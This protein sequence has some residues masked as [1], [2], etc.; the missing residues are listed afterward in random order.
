MWPPL[1]SIPPNHFAAQAS[2]LS[3]TG[4]VCETSTS[5]PVHIPGFGRQIHVFVWVTVS[6]CV[7]FHIRVFLSLIVQPAQE[8]QQRMGVGRLF[9]LC[10]KQAGEVKGGH[11]PCPCLEESKV[12]TW[13]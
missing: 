2:S 3:H 9:A 6:P 12:K 5:V 7:H 11:D 4:E 8:L 10:L 13:G 1:L